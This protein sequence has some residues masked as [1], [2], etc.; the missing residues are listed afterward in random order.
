M[1]RGVGGLGCCVAWG[2]LGQ[3]R[4]VLQDMREFGAVEMGCPGGEQG[5]TLR[6]GSEF[7]QVWVGRRLLSTPRCTSAMHMAIKKYTD[8]TCLKD[9]E[10][11]EACSF[12]RRRNGALWKTVINGVPKEAHTNSHC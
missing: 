2:V 5:G 12:A 1:L 8:V 3:G 9:G 4:V 11:T 7:L 10:I 6:C